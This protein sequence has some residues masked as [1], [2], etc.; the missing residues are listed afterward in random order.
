MPDSWEL[1]G[2]SAWCM[3]LFP[4]SQT[5]P[6]HPAWLPGIK[7]GNGSQGVGVGMQMLQL[8]L[9]AMEGGPADT[10]V[11]PAVLHEFIEG[12]RAVHRRGQPVPILNALH[13]LQRGGQEASLTAQEEYLC[14]HKIIATEPLNP[15]TRVGMV[16]T[17]GHEV[18]GT[19]EDRNADKGSE[20]RNQGIC[21]KGPWR[22]WGGDGR[23]EKH[24]AHLLIA[25]VSIGLVP[26]AEHLPHHDPKA[27]HVAGRGEDPVGDG[28]G[29]CPTDG[30]LPS[31]T[32]PVGQKAEESQYRRA[33]E[34]TV[35]P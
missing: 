30:D 17:T 13:Y 33:W 12:G 10:V 6:P 23:C 25:H 26:E 22:I 35:S 5:C 11:G 24:Q 16:K 19:R 18:K 3:W 7:V 8:C 20:R 14:A 29:G 4:F 34:A 15:L 31:L 9:Q 27:P 32:G 1:H 28:F 2:P 21:R